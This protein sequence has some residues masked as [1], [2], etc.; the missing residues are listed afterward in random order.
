MRATSDLSGKGTPKETNGLGEVDV[1]SSKV[2]DAQT[3][4]SLE[5]FSIEQDPISRQ[6]IAA[7]A[8]LEKADAGTHHAGRR[9]NH[10]MICPDHIGKV[11][12]DTAVDI[13]LQQNPFFVP[14]IEY[15]R[16]SR[17]RRAGRNTS[18]STGS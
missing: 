13:I 14:P 10:A 8:P 1:P 3:P 2:W 9:S 4:R 18:T 12:G 15:L 11:S 17:E 5:H 16:E 6:M 7:C